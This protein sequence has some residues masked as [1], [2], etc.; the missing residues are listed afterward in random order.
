MNINGIE[1]EKSV[2]PCKTTRSPGQ[3][4]NNDFRP[5]SEDWQSAYCRVI[6]ILKTRGCNWELAH[7]VA[8]ESLLSIFQS[9]VNY[10]SL[11]HF[12]C[13]AGKSARYRYADYLR[14]QLNLKNGGGFKR[15]YVDTEKLVSPCNSNTFRMAMLR[16]ELLRYIHS[17]K[18]PIDREILIS[19]LEGVASTELANK[20]SVVRSR[21]QYLRARALKRA[22]IRLSARL[23]EFT[24]KD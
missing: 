22:R 23:S 3:S 1:S 16:E 4:I 11:R 8:S 18:D 21:F 2:H 10:K 6:G 7:D 9:S 13:L 24:A 14:Q 17:I 15:D 19:E 5:N 20:L 12:L